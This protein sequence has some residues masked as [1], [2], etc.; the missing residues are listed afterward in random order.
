[1]AKRKAWPLSRKLSSLPE[2]Q[3]RVSGQ[4]RVYLGGQAY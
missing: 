4:A 1:M 2:Y 3:Y